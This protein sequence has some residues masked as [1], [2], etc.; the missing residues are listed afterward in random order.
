MYVKD[1]CMNDETSFFPLQEGKLFLFFVNTKI[2][3]KIENANKFLNIF[4][5]KINFVY[6]KLKNCY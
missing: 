5:N 4:E 1:D 6:W 2:K 3:I